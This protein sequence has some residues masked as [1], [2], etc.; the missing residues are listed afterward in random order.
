MPAQFV[1]IGRESFGSTIHGRDHVTYV[2]VAA[3]KDGEVKGLRVR[4]IANLGASYA[5]TI[6]NDD[7]A[8]AQ[9]DLAISKTD[10]VISVG[11]LTTRAPWVDV[12]LDME[13]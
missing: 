8:A 3:T 5:C 10:N 12:G 2:D 13:G 1:D 4:T 6:T 9:A 7:I 11:A